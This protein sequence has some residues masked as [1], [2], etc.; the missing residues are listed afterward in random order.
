MRDYTIFTDSTCD[1]APEMYTENGLEVFTMYF[2]MDGRE[3]PDD[4]KTLA[5]HDFYHFG[6]F[7]V[8]PFED[9]REDHQR[10]QFALFM[11]DHHRKSAAGI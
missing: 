2:S 7:D 8:L 9:G 10:F 4:G 11:H 3:Y 5:G 1:L 6:M